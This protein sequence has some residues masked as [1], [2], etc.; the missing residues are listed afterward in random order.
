MNLLGDVELK[1]T[2]LPNALE[3]IVVRESSL[4]ETVGIPA[5]TIIV[6]WAFFWHT[7]NLWLRLISGCAAGFTIQSRKD[8]PG[9]PR[10][11]R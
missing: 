11:P 5:I 1:T 9:F 2:E 4:L 3:F 10:R 7:G 6:M 8:F